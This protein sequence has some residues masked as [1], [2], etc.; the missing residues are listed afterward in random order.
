MVGTGAVPFSCATNVLLVFLLGLLGT[1][2]RCSLRSTRQL[3]A[4]CTLE[5]PVMV[6]L[7]L[8][9]CLKASLPSFRFA[10]A[11]PCRCTI[12]MA[13]PGLITVSGCRV[14]RGVEEAMLLELIYECRRI[15]TIIALLVLN[16]THSR[17]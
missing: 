9:G 7:A 13:K 12:G 5:K 3:F 2:A 6:G 11:L 17:S 15:G 16:D 14:G 1:A 10:G 8:N 4:D